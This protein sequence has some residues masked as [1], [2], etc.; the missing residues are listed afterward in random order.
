MKC[1]E[2]GQFRTYLFLSFL[3]SFIVNLLCR[4]RGRE[5][6][7]PGGG[8]EL[9][10]QML[11]FFFLIKVKWNG[12]N[13]WCCFKVITGVRKPQKGMLSW[14]RTSQSWGKQILSS[15]GSTTSVAFAIN[16]FALGCNKLVRLSQ[17]SI[18]VWLFL[19]LPSN[20]RL[21]QKKCLRVT[22][23]GKL[24]G[25][26]SLYCWPPVW[27]V[28]NQLYNNWLFL[29]FIYKNRLIQTGQIGGQQYSDTY[30]YSISWANFYSCKNYKNFK[31]SCAPGAQ[32]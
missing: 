29:F 9:Q 15:L 3:F 10:D 28:W 11:K 18:Q 1:W 17:F 8:G 24:K 2:Y 12:E 19:A 31:F 27:L 13:V 30:P 23:Q 21:R 26:V 7:G 16:H 5:G 6:G 22:N 4:G 32:W 20:N 14:G 25:D